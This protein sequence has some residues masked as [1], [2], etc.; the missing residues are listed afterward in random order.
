[1]SEPSIPSSMRASV[2]EAP[3]RLA[4]AEVP[5]PKP[6][7]GE[8]LVEVAHCGIC[9]TDLHMVNEGW[10]R[11]GRTGGHEWSGTVVALGDGVP[12]SGPAGPTGTG[13]GIAVGDLVVGGPMWCGECVPCRAGRPAVCRQGSMLTG[14]QGPQAFAEYTLAPAAAVVAVPH[15]LDARTAALAEPLA[16]SLHAITRSGARAGDRVLV[17]GGGPVGLLAVAGLVARGVTDITVSEPGARRRER[18]LRVGAAA[19][20]APGDLPA[21]PQ[22]PIG[23]VEDAFD[24]V[25]ECSGAAPALASALGLLGPGGTAVIVG[26]GM[27][28]PTFDP[29]RVLLNELT[30]TGAYEYDLTGFPDALALL[31]GGTLPLADLIHPDDVGLDGMADAFARLGTGDIES[32]VLIEPRR[33]A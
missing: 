19:A 13:G 18:A 5:V 32:K 28:Q 17:T 21:S 12:S 11:P 26:T 31:A 16:V 15:G 14:R 3:R 1:M 8:V 24:V 33:N 23:C 2:L 22:G 6:G 4:V 27:S 20:I 25:L 9:G 10:G 29:N 30:L 7:P